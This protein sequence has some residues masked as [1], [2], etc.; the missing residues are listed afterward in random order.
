MGANGKLISS[1]PTI[2]TS[3]VLFRGVSLRLGVANSIIDQDLTENS[4]E[5]SNVPNDQFTWPDPD[6]FI[7]DWDQSGNELQSIPA[8]VSTS[9][10][11]MYR[12]L[13]IFFTGEPGE[14]YL[15]SFVAGSA[16]QYFIDFQANN[17][18]YPLTYPSA[19]PADSE[20]ACY[21]ALIIAGYITKTTGMS[22]C[23]DGVNYGVPEVDVHIDGI[24][25]VNPQ[26]VTSTGT[27]GSYLQ[28]IESTYQG[29]DL[30]ITPEKDN[31]PACGITSLDMDMIK[32]FLLSS[33]MCWQYPWQSIAADANMNGSISIADF[34]ILRDI[35]LGAPY[36]MES[37]TFI[38]TDDYV[39]L[40][41]PYCNSQYSPSFN[42]YIDKVNFQASTMVEDF[43][44]VKVGD[45]D[46]SCE[47]CDNNGMLQNPG[48][49]EEALNR[50]D[51]AIL[52]TC[53]V[54]AYPDGSFRLE[55]RATEDINVGIMNL[56]FEAKS[57]MFDWHNVSGLN[58]SND[59]MVNQ[60]EGTVRLLYSNPV[61]YQRTVPDGE[62]LLSVPMSAG[63]DV[64]NLVQVGETWRNS[65]TLHGEVRP[66]SI[67]LTKTAGRLLVRPN[68]VRSTIFL[69]TAESG[70]YRLYNMQGAL[71]QQGNVQQGDNEIHLNG[72]LPGMYLIQIK[73]S[74]ERLIVK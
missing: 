63:T 48:Q 6:Y 28:E 69:T 64:G 4:S 16:Y 66:V 18:C 47:D 7:V 51:S 44:A 45:V 61:E 26:Y 53:S 54:Q 23:T 73:E 29:D 27:N 31:Y 22:S 11:G 38:P 9:E 71:V 2:L 49:E 14:C 62:V 42:P 60:V 8:A 32:E 58:G 20:E 12:L 25:S 17:Y 40:S 57:E 15:A 36:S 24:N 72:V 52:L 39:Q 5:I 68:P 30:R 43:V 1:L 59:W 55:F 41:T 74:T 34:L 46:G 10:P 3:S 19:E 37:W 35:V 65:N 70:L 56:T 33:N 50:D 67:A 13:T 21:P